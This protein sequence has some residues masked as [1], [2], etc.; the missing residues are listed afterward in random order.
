MVSR[1]DMWALMQLWS[2]MQCNEQLFALLTG[3]Q[4]WTAA[5]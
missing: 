1:I 4:G 2:A 3:Q 5:Q